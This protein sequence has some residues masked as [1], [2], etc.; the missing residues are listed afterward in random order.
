MKTIRNNTFETNSS[1]T[2]SI[3]VSNTHDWNYN[4]PITVTPEWYGEFGWEWETWSSIEEKIAYMIRCLVSYDYTK[5]TLQDK[6]KP[7]QER[8]R[9]LGIY[10]DLPTYEEWEDGYVD[11][12]DWYQA[13]ME[14]IYNDDDTLLR[15]LLSNNSYIEGGND[16]E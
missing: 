6:V 9:N 14:E 12:E 2:H 7:I 4:L 15:F 13:E 8:L 11:H 16:N 5:K 3:T 10:F 1:S